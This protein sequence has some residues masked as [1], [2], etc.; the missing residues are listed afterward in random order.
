M[1]GQLAEFWEDPEVTFGWAR[2]DLRRYADH[3]EWVLLLNAVM[4]S[5]PGTE[6]GCG[7][8][9]DWTVRLPGPHPER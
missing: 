7:P 8:P 4:V 5:V 2:E 1:S 3:E 9:L 6:P